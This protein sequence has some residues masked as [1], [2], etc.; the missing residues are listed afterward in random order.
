MKIKLPLIIS[1]L[2]IILSADVSFSFYNNQ[3]ASV[4][5]GQPDFSQTG[6]HPPSANTLAWPKDVHYDG[7]YL[8]IVDR[9][10]NRV[11][12]FD[13]IPLT[14]NT[15][16]VAVIGQYDF[17]QNNPNQGLGLTNPSSYTLNSPQ[18][19]VG[20]GNTLLVADTVNNRVLIYQII[21]S[22]VDDFITSG[23][24]IYADVVIGQTCFSSSTKDQ[25]GSVGPNTLDQPGD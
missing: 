7:T 24:S 9:D 17:F 12:V 20:D 14:P 19:I 21:T 25:G 5:I 10:N 18:G 13:S 3:E 22:K 4:V 1:L 16:A 2:T 8:Y 15:S 11:L 23:T 6:S